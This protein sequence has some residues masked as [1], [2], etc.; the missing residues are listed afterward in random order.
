MEAIDEALR[1]TA[2]CG[3]GI[4]P[5][6]AP[7]VSQREKQVAEFMLDGM[8]IFLLARLGQLMCFFFNLAKNAFG[9]WPVKAHAAGFFANA[10][11]FQEGRKIFRYAA[12][13]R[14]SFLLLELLPV[15]E[16]VFAIFN[17]GFAKYMRVTMDQLIDDALDRK[18]NA[19]GE[20]IIDILEA[21]MRDYPD[22]KEFASIFS[23]LLPY[24]KVGIPL[25]RFVPTV[26]KPCIAV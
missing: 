22:S 21:A 23:S 12:Q 17:F 6:E 15:L 13:N 1:C 7:K 9:I 25:R 8:L 2:Q 16:H 4:D 11:R 26:P 10:I 19:P 3:L 18:I 14:F 20:N 5:D 24:Y